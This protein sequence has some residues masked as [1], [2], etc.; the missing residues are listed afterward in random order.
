MFS[1]GK[2]GTKDIIV[3]LLSQKWPLTVK[4]VWLS[5]RK[6]NNVSYQAIHKDLVELAF[7]KIIIKHGKNYSLN[8]SYI[9]KMQKHWCAIDENYKEESGSSVGIITGNKVV[10][11]T[12]I[13]SFEKND[14]NVGFIPSVFISKAT[15]QEFVENSSKNVLEE[16]AKKV[17]VRDFEYIISRMVERREFKNSPLVAIDKLNELA[18]D[19]YWGKV[20]CKKAGE[21]IEI[22]IDSSVYT[23]KKGK[24]FYDKI[25]EYF[26]QILGYRLTKRNILETTYTYKRRSK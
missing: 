22:K 18:H 11:P 6:H 9:S 12:A 23:T 8:P 24:F 14:L 20:S 26:M 2:T 10:T 19:F 17:A 25:Y 16:I 7:S 5:I 3:S 21:N 13:Y 1:E 4:E 15:L